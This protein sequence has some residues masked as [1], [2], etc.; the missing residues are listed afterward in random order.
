[1]GKKKTARRIRAFFLCFEMMGK[2]INNI[3]DISVSGV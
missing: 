1:M 3:M 2:R